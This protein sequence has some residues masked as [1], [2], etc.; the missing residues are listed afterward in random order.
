MDHADTTP[1]I[2]DQVGQTK[3]RARALCDDLY[4]QRRKRMAQFISANVDLSAYGYSA[5]FRSGVLFRRG[6]REYEVR[7]NLFMIE[8][9][10]GFEVM[11]LRSKMTAVVARGNND[12]KE[13]FYDRGV[14]ETLPM[15][16]EEFETELVGFCVDIGIDDIKKY[17]EEM[18]SSYVIR[19]KEYCMI[20][21]L[22]EELVF[23][24]LRRTKAPAK[25]QIIFYTPNITLDELVNRLR[26]W[27]MLEMQPKKRGARML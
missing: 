12:V 21:K 22:G 5:G 13:W 2:V 16:W 8:G 11:N 3:G 20:R 25:Y 1:D 26:D 15:S 14:S 24:K 27:E 10:N 23:K 9:Q 4:K 17:R 7:M 6:M 18:W 19:L